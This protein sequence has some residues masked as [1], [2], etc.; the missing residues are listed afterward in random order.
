M[1]TFNGRSWLNQKKSLKKTVKIKQISLK[2][3]YYKLQLHLI[4]KWTNCN[5][6]L[7]IV[8]SNIYKHWYLKIVNAAK[9]LNKSISTNT[10]FKQKCDSYTEHCIYTLFRMT[11]PLHGVLKVGEVVDTEGHPTG[12]HRGAGH[13]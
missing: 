8:V 7:A 2:K 13:L 6:S 3:L 12:C 9:N 5:Q 4:L 1:N 11:Y 10:S